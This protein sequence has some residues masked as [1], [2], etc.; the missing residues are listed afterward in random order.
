MVLDFY[1]I[2]IS[3]LRKHGEL[4]SDSTMDKSIFGM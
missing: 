2:L 1:S 3:K 4:I